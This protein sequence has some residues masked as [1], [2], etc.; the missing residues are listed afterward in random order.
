MSRDVSILPVYDREGITIYQG[1][2]QTVLPTLGPVDHVITD[3]PYSPWAHRSLAGRPV[4]PSDLNFAAM[5]ESNRAVIAGQIARLV[6]YWSLVF[7]DDWGIGPWRDALAAAGMDMVRVGIWVKVNCTPQ[8]S[9][10]RPASGFEAIVITHPPGRKRWNGGGLPAI[11]TYP[12]VASRSSDGERRVHPT[13]KPLA[14]MRMLVAQFTN[15]G[16]VILDMFMG[17]GT[18]LVAAA[19][20]G[21]RAI[22]IEQ[23]DR[24]IKQAIGRL[25]QGNLPIEAALGGQEWR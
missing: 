12:I 7:C 25:A 16:D 11:W 5:S 24:Y 23:N 22:G 8:F 9:G 21:R 18:T 1:D 17:S 10:D 6:R 14:L 20:L 15:P 13:Q 19:Q 2:C 4:R 3:P